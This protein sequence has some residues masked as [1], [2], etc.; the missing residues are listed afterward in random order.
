MDKLKKDYHHWLTETGQEEKAGD[1]RQKDGDFNGAIT[2][3]LRAGVPG[4]AARLAL[5]EPEI[6]SDRVL[7]E[8]IIMV[9][10]EKFWACCIYKVFPF[11]ISV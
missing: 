10:L 9:R 5:T 7:V 11:L 2:L 3:Y 8:R 1:L 4:K 6:S